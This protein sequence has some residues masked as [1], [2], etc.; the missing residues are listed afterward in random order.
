M[1]RKLKDVTLV[2]L[3]SVETK[4]SMQAIKDSQAQCEFAA[5]VYYFGEMKSL[6]D[7]ARKLWY[8]IPYQVKTSH[9]LLIQ[10]DGWVLDGSL[11]DNQWLKYDYI[12]APW[13]WHLRNQVGNGGFSLRSTKLARFLADNK[14]QYPYVD[15][16]PEDDLLCRVY[17]PHL[18]AMHG[19]KFAPLSVADQFSFERSQPHKTFGFHGLFNWPHVLPPEGLRT[20]KQLAT[21]YAKSKV[22]WQEAFHV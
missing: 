19:F 1:V 4:L 14:K 6:T 16:H 17:G 12:G 11:W 22:E 2:V 20:R 8:W 7:V 5:G 10:Y 3:D 13:G 21:N 18:A 15:S 9:F